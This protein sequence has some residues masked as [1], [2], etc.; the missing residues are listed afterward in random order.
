MPEKPKNQ[1]NKDMEGGVEV[2]IEDTGISVSEI[3]R[4]SEG[5]KYK[6]IRGMMFQVYMN[7]F[8]V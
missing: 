3:V 1:A 8:R 6:G 7:V 4:V 2:Y 5:G